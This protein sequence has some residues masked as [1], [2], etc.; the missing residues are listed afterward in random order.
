VAI[1]YYLHSSAL[2][3][4]V[5]C[6]SQAIGGPL[7]IEDVFLDPKP[8]AAEVDEQT[9][10]ETGGSEIPEDL[11]DVFVSELTDGFDLDDEPLVH[12]EIGE[13]LPEE[14]AVLVIDIERV[15]LPNF[16]AKLPES[17]RQG[18]FIDLL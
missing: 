1:R 10:L 8:R 15:L 3:T 12:Q 13:V 18:V 6:F 17:M 7:V 14:S 4:P 5:T 2:G 16:E 11:G 9:V